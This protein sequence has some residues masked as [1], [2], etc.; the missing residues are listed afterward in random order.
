MKMRHDLAKLDELRFA[1]RGIVDPAILCLEMSIDSADALF[2]ALELDSRD[3]L[4]AESIALPDFPYRRAGGEGVKLR[5]CAHA[6][7][8][9][10]ADKCEQ[11]APGTEAAALDADWNP[12]GLQRQGEAIDKRAE[13][14]FL[15]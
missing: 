9:R 12:I 13:P 15:Q 11:A 7:S 4:A 10:G 5:R 8:R 6:P 2:A 1:N 3:A 14:D